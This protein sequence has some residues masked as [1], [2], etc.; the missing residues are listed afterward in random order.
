MILIPDDLFQSRFASIL[1]FPPQTVNK[2]S[3]KYG[4][5]GLQM[6]K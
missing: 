3:E 2:S 6:I 5:S 1:S 4:G